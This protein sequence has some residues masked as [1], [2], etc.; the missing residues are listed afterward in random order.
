MSVGA[1]QDLRVKIDQL[2]EELIRIL[3]ARF[4]LVEEIG[5]LKV[6]S[7]LGVVDLERKARVLARF[8]MMA[9]ESNLSAE[10]TEKLYELIHGEAVRRQ[11]SE[12][13]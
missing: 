4:S 3:S 5:N 13:C 9:S 10:F 11:A 1:I 6:A 7:A 12:S 2:D 8:Q